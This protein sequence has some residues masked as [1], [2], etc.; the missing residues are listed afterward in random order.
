MV[1]VE[2]VC[3]TAATAAAAAATPKSI[4]GGDRVEYTVHS[5]HRKEHIIMIL[6]IMI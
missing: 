6:M 1:Q 3:I 5:K 2:T 4:Y